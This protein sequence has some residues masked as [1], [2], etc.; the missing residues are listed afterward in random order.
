MKCSQVADFPPWAV[1][2]GGRYADQFD[3]ALRNALGYSREDVRRAVR[4]DDV[5]WDWCFAGK[6]VHK[7]PPSDM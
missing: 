5:E 2:G 6:Q 1:H 3:E 7:G 4:R